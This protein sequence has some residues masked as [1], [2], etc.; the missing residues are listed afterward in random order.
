MHERN[1]PTF[2]TAFGLRGDDAR[3]GCAEF[4][5]QT[6]A[7]GFDGV[8]LA[9]C[10]EG[11]ITP[12]STQAD[13]RRIAGQLSSAGLAATVLSCP[14]NRITEVAAGDPERRQ[15]ALA[16]V[17]SL[18]DRAAWLGAGTLVISPVCAGGDGTDTSYADIASLALESLLKLRFEAEQRG[19]VLSS[20]IEP[21]H[22]LLSPLEARNFIDRVNL[23]FA[24]L[25]L[26]AVAAAPSLIKEYM[27]VLTHRITHVRIGTGEV[28]LETRPEA[29]GTHYAGEI[30]AALCAVR[31]DAALTIIADREPGNAMRYLRSMIAAIEMND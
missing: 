29:P 20:R 21:E 26:D 18:L 17:T 28:A 2:K 25:S 31:Y 9:L 6:A 11:P 4:L 7:A 5:S 24:G 19:V 10:D 15:T 16:S 14:P 23:P 1:S 12:G 30:V 8:D 13:L 27:G 22:F 3:L